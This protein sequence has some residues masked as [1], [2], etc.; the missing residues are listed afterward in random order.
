MKAHL[1]HSRL[2]T[3]C[4]SCAVYSPHTKSVEYLLSTATKRIIAAKMG[5]HIMLDLEEWALVLSKMLR[6]HFNVD[7]DLDLDVEVPLQRL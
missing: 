7:L 4:T 2:R 3:I 6:F 1:E 5:D